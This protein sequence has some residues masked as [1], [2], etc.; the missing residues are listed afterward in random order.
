M[1][2]RSIFDCKTTEINNIGNI[3]IDIDY[4]PMDANNLADSLLEQTDIYCWYEG[5]QGLPEKGATFMRDHIFTPILSVRGETR[6]KLYSL[7]GWD[8]DKYRSISQM[9]VS[10]PMAQAINEFSGNY[11]MI[12]SFD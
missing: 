3:K 1:F 11:E 2:Q 12:N 9:P 10:T 4:N 6:F 8:F 5:T 7:R